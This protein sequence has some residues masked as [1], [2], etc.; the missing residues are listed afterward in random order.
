MFFCTILMAW[1]KFF[2]SKFRRTPFALLSLMF[3]PNLLLGFS[4]LTQIAGGGSSPSLALSNL[5]SCISDLLKANLNFHCNKLIYYFYGGSENLR[6][7]LK[8]CLWQA[9]GTLEKEMATI[10][11][12]P[13]TS[14]C[15]DIIGHSN[16]CF[17]M[18]TSLM[19]KGWD[20]ILGIPDP[21]VDRKSRFSIHHQLAT[22][23]YIV[24]ISFAII[25]L[26][27]LLRNF[28][29]HPPKAHTYLL[30]FPPAK[31]EYLRW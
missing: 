26:V 5:I 25:L 14:L 29:I 9:L 1:S 15:D 12:T 31:H 11:N 3:W 19:S 4:L 8:S 7:P 21:P 27:P 17:M 24:R 16:E 30:T 28:H 10:V 6:K 18:L 23:S 13:S 22:V 20:T 2:T